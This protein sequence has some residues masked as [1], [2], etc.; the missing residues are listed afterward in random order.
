[1]SQVPGEET[2]AKVLAS[3]DMVGVGVCLQR[4]KQT[5]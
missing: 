3:K 2:K 4:E 5:E 1:M